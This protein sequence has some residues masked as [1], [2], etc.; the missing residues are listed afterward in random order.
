MTYD[1]ELLRQNS[2][3]I[4]DILAHHDVYVNVDTM[5]VKSCGRDDRAQVL[6]L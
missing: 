2:Q 5:K 6:G 3:S 1:S 4:E